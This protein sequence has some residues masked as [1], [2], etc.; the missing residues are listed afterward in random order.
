MFGWRI[1]GRWTGG[2]SSAEIEFTLVTR[3]REREELTAW[4]LRHLVEEAVRECPSLSG[5]LT[6]AIVD[7]PE[8]LPQIAR[9]LTRM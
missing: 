7:E 3:S 2:G 8:E 9:S 6:V 5:D 1:K 4:A